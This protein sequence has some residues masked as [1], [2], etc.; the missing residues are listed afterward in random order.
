MVRI[1][2]KTPNHRINRSPLLRST[3][4]VKAFTRCAG[5]SNLEKELNISASE[6]K[7]LLRDKEVI[8]KKIMNTIKSM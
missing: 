5:G 7:M 1:L 8:R 4:N 3:G 2:E 6:E